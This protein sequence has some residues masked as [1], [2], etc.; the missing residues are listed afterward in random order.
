LVS[1]IIGV[2]LVA[3]AYAERLPILLEHGIGLWDVVAEAHRDGS[4]DS[5]IRNQINNDL[6]GLL[7]SL[8][9]LI[10]IGF[11]GGTAAR[12]GLKLL[13]ER[14]DHYRI[15]LL[16]SSSPAYTKP[17]LEKLGGWRMLK[18]TPD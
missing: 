3:L 11:N 5:N 10:T 14:A 6:I 12:I 4:L 2:D 9:R 13:K 17:Y 15:V 8:P 18:N 16:P 1:E 7:D